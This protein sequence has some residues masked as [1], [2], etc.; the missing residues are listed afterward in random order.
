VFNHRAAFAPRFS[1]TSL[2]DDGFLIKHL[3][4]PLDM[5]TKIGMVEV[6]ENG[7]IVFRK[8]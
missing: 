5:V 3:S 7:E 2:L 8:E 4:D 1:P 6:S